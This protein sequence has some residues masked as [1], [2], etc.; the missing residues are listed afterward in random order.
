MPTWLLNILGGGLIDK[1]L[2]FIPNPEEKAKAQQQMQAAFLD[3][4]LKADSE[5]RDIN[6]VE[7]AS[8]SLFVA[9]WRPAVG[10]MC[11]ATP[12]SPWAVV[13]TISWLFQAARVGVPPLPHLDR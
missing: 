6:K 3:A 4:A 1:V 7:A 5:Q 8:A 11:V 12:V 10:W 2:A 9:G 13:P